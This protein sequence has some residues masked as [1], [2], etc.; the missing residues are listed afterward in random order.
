MAEMI[1]IHTKFTSE[2]IEAI[3]IAVEIGQAANRSD[4][5]RRA[6]TEKLQE[7]TVLKEMKN[8]KLK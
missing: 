8:R 4:F 3:D 5:I 1:P 2:M 6:V 7:L